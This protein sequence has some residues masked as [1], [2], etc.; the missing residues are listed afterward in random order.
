MDVALLPLK[1]FLVR[2]SSE[3]KVLKVPPRGTRRCVYPKDG[4]DVAAASDGLDAPAF[5]SSTDMSTELKICGRVSS[6]VFYT[7]T[8][9]CT[10]RQTVLIGTRTPP[11]P[12]LLRRRIP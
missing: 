5:Q 1:R 6:P 4:L 2:I 10:D 9:C 3:L 7:R 12:T 11:P 8:V